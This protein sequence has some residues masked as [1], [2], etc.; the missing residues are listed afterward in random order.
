MTEEQGRRPE[1]SHKQIWD[2][3][4]A[5][6]EPKGLTERELRTIHQRWIDARVYADGGPR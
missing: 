5:E 1:R 2:Q 4:R 3:F 6:F